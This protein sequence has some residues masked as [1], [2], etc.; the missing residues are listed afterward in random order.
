VVR[1]TYSH[2]IHGTYPMGET[3]PAPLLAILRNADGCK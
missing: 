2:E 3:P 1:D